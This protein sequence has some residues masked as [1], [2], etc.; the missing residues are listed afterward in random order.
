MSTI[1]T[2]IRG[3]ITNILPNKKV[4]GKWLPKRFVVTDSNGISITCSCDKFCDPIVQDQIVASVEKRDSDY[5][6]YYVITSPPC[7]LPGENESAVIRTIERC[8]QQVSREIHNY[9]SMINGNGAMFNRAEAAYRS[10]VRH[11]QSK[12]PTRTVT[13][14]DVINYLDDCSESNIQIAASVENVTLFNQ[15]WKKINV[16]RRLYSIGLNKREIDE[17]PGSLTQLYRDILITPYKIL[18][19]SLEKCAHIMVMMGRVIDPLHV[20]CGTIIR[21]IHRQNQESGHMYIPLNMIRSIY[22]DFNSIKKILFDLFDVVYSHNPYTATMDPIVDDIEYNAYAGDNDEYEDTNNGYDQDLIARILA[23]AAAEEAAARVNDEITINEVQPTITEEFIDYRDYPYQSPLCRV[24]AGMVTKSEVRPYDIDSYPDETINVYLWPVYR[25]ELMVSELPVLMKNIPPLD[26][27]H[28][29]V[30]SRDDLSD[31]QIAA[32][33]LAYQHRMVCITGGAGS[34]KTTIA[35]E[36]FYNNNEDNVTTALVAYTGKAASRL[37][38]LVK[39]SG[40]STVH[41]YLSSGNDPYH[42]IIDESSM[43]TSELFVQLLER[44][45]S[46]ERITLI[47]DNNQLLPIG[48]GAFFHHYIESGVVPL[49]KLTTKHRYRERGGVNGIILNADKIAEGVR[50]QPIRLERCNNFIPIQSLNSDISPV[51]NAFVRYNDSIG[52]NGAKITTRDFTIICPIVSELPRLNSYI[53]SVFRSGNNMVLSPK[54]ILYIEDRVMMLENDYDFNI[55]NGEEGYVT[56]LHPEHG[57]VLVDFT[58][59]GDNIPNMV[60]V[61]TNEQAR[62]DSVNRDRTDGILCECIELSYANTV[63]KFQ[64]SESEYVIGVLPYRGNSQPSSFMS[65]NLLYTLITRGRT[66]VYIVGDLELMNNMASNWPTYGRDMTE[67]KL[68]NI[69]PPFALGG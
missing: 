23:E 26:V 59:P 5:G 16:I 57:Y 55:F 3:V 68:R 47:G 21:D 37:R 22:T 27:S 51:I 7:L 4:D 1:A 54:N 60:R 38:I 20:R 69:L 14:I 58:Q 66:C 8:L 53:Q 28:N 64:G 56:E 34:G 30:F 40:A 43:L 63:H 44:F 29:R 49:Y 12:N 48:P 24:R 50:G 45:P 62:L 13:S 65:R 31:D 15:H 9:N 67:T 19:L 39:N 61:F 42:L 41:R 36:L 33:K 11:L 46:I 17:Y 25:V 32:C 18:H 10:I 2:T 35:N 6:S 52:D